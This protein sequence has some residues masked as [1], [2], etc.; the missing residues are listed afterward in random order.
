VL[1]HINKHVFKNPPQLMENANGVTCFIRQ[2]GGAALHFLTTESGAP[3]YCDEN[4]EYWRAYE[5]VGGLCLDA[6]ETPEDF[7]Q[8]GLAFGC[9]Q[10]Q[11]SDYPADTLYETIPNFHNTP[12]R[13]RQLKEAIA[14]NRSGRLENCRKEIEFYLAHE[15][16]GGKLHAM[17]EEGLLPL[18]VTHN[19]TKLNNVLLDPETHAP[20]C[21][22]DL[23][24]VMPGLSAYDFGDSIRFGAATAAEDEQDASKMKLDLTLFEAFSRGFLCGAPN[25]TEN[26]KKALPLGAFTMTLECGSRFLKDYLD[27]DLYFRT[28]YPEHNLVRCRTQMAMCA[29]MLKHWADMEAIVDKVSADI[30]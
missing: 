25:L 10:N 3:C 14:E 22:L 27:G 2:K 17:L 23:D 24:T 9:F 4:G 6:A 5:F 16:L 20:L 29:D 26:E 15:E 21:V 11:L 28:H 8:S 18:R 19:D 12:D 30:G 7:Y 13:F 1:Q